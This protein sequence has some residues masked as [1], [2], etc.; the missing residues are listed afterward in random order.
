MITEWTVSDDP[1]DWANESF[2]IAEAVNTKYCTMQGKS[3]NGP[4]SGNVTIDDAYVQA[5][6][7]IIKRRLQQ[8]GVRLARMLDAAFGN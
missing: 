1:I 2:V 6:Q 7:P 4:A 3:C 8:A 5:N